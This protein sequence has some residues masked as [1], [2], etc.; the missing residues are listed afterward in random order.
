MIWTLPDTPTTKATLPTSALTIAIYL[1]FIFVSYQEHIRSE[2]PPTVLTLYLGLSLLLDLARA[3][4][5][6]YVP[7]VH[8]S[9]LLFLGCYCV[10]FAIFLLEIVEKR[11]LLKPK[12]Q[13]ISAENTSS[14]YSRSLFVWL[15]PLFVKGF[16]A[17]LTQKDLLPIESA[18]V[19]ASEP[20]SLKEKWN[21]SKQACLCKYR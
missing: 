10:K 13:S 4:T 8:S 15:N 5:L 16:K 9:A 11:R 1:L 6:L 21:Q 3:R 7:K 17:D 12:W 20:T 2:R 18:I 19:S 14:V